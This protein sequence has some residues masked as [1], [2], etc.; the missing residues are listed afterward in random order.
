MGTRWDTE[1]FFLLA[2]DGLS[3]AG[4][5][6]LTWWLRYRSGLFSEPE[7]FTLPLSVYALLTLFWIT[8]FALRGQYR[9]LYHFGRFQS[10]QQVGASVVVGLVLLFVLTFDPGQP[11]SPGRLL[12]L[13]YGLVVFL[14]AG[15]GRVLF[16][17]VQKRLLERG[18]G[19]RPTLV[20]GDGPRGRD[21]ELQFRRHPGMGYRVVGRVAVDA[22]LSE[23]LPGGL[24]P[25]AGRLAEL[26][27][28]LEERSVEEVVVTTRER[29][30]LFQVISD[31]VPRGVE[32]Q[33]VPD[34][35]E[36]V[37]GSHKAM[38]VWGLPL[39]Q[40]FPHLMAPW[41]F[42]LKRGSAK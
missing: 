3:I 35:T 5:T 6:A 11:V 8:I 32:V 13:G 36:L 14:G 40:V 16:R 21:L 10:L 19:L 34:L 39:I 37:L 26:P 17:T 23:S 2:V 41:Q 29:E 22:S 9:R 24:E 25:A 7:P 30:V 20:I 27:A 28:L 31:C 42:L 4:A 12:L 18:L 33:I 1:K 38:D 15:A